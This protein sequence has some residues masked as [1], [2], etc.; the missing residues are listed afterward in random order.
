M[1]K[2]MLEKDSEIQS[3]A[4]SLSQLG[5]DPN[6]AER[7]DQILCNSTKVNGELDVVGAEF[8]ID[9]D[10]KNSPAF[11]FKRKLVLAEVLRLV[12]DTLDTS[13][14]SRLSLSSLRAEQHT[15]D[16]AINLGLTQ[17]LRRARL[18]EILTH[19]IILWKHNSN[20]SGKSSLPKNHTSL[21]IGPNRLSS[22]SFQKV[23]DEE[24]KS[25]NMHIADGEYRSF[26]FLP[27]KRIKG[28]TMALLP[29]MRMA[30]KY[31]MLLMGGLPLSDSRDATEEIFKQW[32]FRINDVGEDDFEMLSHA[33]IVLN[34]LVVRHP[35][36]EYHE[37]E[38]LTVGLEYAF[39][40]QMTKYFQRKKVGH[41]EIPIV[42]PNIKAK[43]M[44][45]VNE[46]NRLEHWHQCINN[47]MNIAYCTTASQDENEPG[48]RI[49]GSTTVFPE[50]AVDLEKLGTQAVPLIQA[51]GR[52]IKNRI[53]FKL[54]SI[55]EKMTG[56]DY[57][58][59]E[60]KARIRRYLDGMFLKRQ[61]HG[62]RNLTV[63]KNDTGTCHVM[64]E[65]R[66]SPLTEEFIIDTAYQPDKQEGRK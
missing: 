1:I 46:V 65:I 15:L 30:E 28:G 38:P 47:Q 22:P 39:A 50:K 45:T 66:W 56:G 19:Q 44:R 9:P 10:L 40:A 57:E 51:Q 58:E 60:I 4:E 21:V 42:H 49:Y 27:L 14:R 2:A 59:D 12:A 53:F 33:A 8:A 25:S 62:F 32:T 43:Y 36:P 17:V 41:W 37:Q 34:N 29:Y 16:T 11:T 20:H 3:R 7:L 23:I 48:V 13:Q 55:L 52:A 64:V 54:R 18:R 61:I 24:L 31:H 35:Y 26:L 63:K 5:T 6:S